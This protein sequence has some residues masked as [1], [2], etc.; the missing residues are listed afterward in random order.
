MPA[1]AALSRRLILS[2]VLSAGLA[3][4]G[5]AQGPDVGSVAI[6]PIPP[7]QARIWIYRNFVPSE[8]LNLAQVMINGAVAG[9]AEPGGGAF[10]RDVPPGHYRVSVPSYGRDFDQTANFDL[11]PGEQAY[12]KI[13]TLNAWTTGGDLSSFKRDTFYARLMNPR[14]AQGEVANSRFYGGN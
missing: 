8:S 2:A 7:G 12:V 13:D 10:Y 14:L 5:C 11:A 4:A 1:L 3:A 9:Y 6:R